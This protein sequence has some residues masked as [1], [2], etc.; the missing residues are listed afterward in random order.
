MPQVNHLRSN[1]YSIGG[2]IVAVSGGRGFTVRG[3]HGSPNRV[4]YYRAF[5]SQISGP[6]LMRMPMYG[7]IVALAG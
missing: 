1:S 3:W 5:V 4:V 2:P 6:H 7:V